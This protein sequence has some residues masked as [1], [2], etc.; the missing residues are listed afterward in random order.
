MAIALEWSAT[1]MTIATEMVA[2]GLVGHW[3]DA[4]LA[5]RIPVFL[6]IGFA[7]GGLLATLSLARIAKNRGAGR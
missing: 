6:L 3:L 1:I 5:L 4:K 2:P 7:L